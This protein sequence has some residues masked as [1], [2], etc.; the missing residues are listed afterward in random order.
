MLHIA[1]S[2]NAHHAMKSLTIPQNKNERDRV[3]PET[4]Y[5][6][7]QQNENEIAIF[8]AGLDETFKERICAAR[9]TQAAIQGLSLTQTKKK[10]KGRG[11]IDRHLELDVVNELN[12]RLVELRKMLEALAARV[13]SKAKPLK[14]IYESLEPSRWRGRPSLILK[15]FL[16]HPIIGEVNEENSLFTPPSFPHTAPRT[17]SDAFRYREEPYNCVAETLNHSHELSKRSSQICSFYSSDISSITQV[18]SSSG[19]HSSPE[20]GGRA[21]IGIFTSIFSRRHESQQS[22]NVVNRIYRRLRRE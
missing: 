1:P 7:F 17:S 12:W 16:W 18:G 6:L 20:G 3:S 15:R 21:S 8:Y 4:D 9:E 22:E 2:M 11:Q 19:T 14:E 10:R 13:L 5:R